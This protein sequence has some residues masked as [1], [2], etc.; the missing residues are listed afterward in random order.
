MGKGGY[1]F[2]AGDLLRFGR[3][4]RSDYVFVNLADLCRREDIERVGS[5]VSD[6]LSCLTGWDL[7]L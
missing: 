2:F 6:I 5:P 1:R 4:Q 3:R 7:E